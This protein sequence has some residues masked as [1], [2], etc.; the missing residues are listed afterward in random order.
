MFGDTFVKLIR[1]KF[2]IRS[3]IQLV[4][5]RKG[6]SRYYTLNNKKR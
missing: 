1:K 3:I 5:K 6:L 2:K 4:E